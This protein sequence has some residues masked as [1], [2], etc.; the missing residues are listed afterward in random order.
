MAKIFFVNTSE[1]VSQVY[2]VKPN[3]IHNVLMGL[4]GLKY[5]LF[6]TQ[7][8]LFAKVR[9]NSSKKSFDQKEKKKKSQERPNKDAHRWGKRFLAERNR[10]L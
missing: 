3:I 9:K 10:K 4:T 1:Q 8:K 5:Q 6:P 2:F 7:P